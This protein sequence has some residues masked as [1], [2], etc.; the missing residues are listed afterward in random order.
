MIGKNVTVGPAAISHGN[1]TVTV[2]ETK[3][4]SQPNSLSGGVTTPVD[5][6]EVVVS[7]DKSRMFLLQPE[8]SLDSIVDAIN[9][10]GAAPSDLMAILEALKQAGALNANIEII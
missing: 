8:A 10:V 7:Q 5:R 4:V 9:K 3:S 6:S 2:S 1:L